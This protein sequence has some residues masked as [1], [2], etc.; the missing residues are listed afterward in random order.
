[1]RP[2][3]MKVAAQA[4]D[5]KRAIDDIYERGLSEPSSDGNTLQLCA[6]M[7]PVRHIQLLQESAEEGWQFLVRSRRCH[8]VRRRRLALCLPFDSNGTVARI[9]LHG[10]LL[11]PA[12][13]LA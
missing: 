8:P 6:A 7:R 9:L 4:N 12:A 10:Y 3:R 1:M 5:T 2:T 11:A 13:A